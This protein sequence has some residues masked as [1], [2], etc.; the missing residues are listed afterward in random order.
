MTETEKAQFERIKDAYL[1]MLNQACG[2]WDGP[3][4]KGYD[5]MYLSSY[6]RAID[7]AFELGWIKEEEM[8]R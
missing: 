3:T 8:L 1:E 4:F 5:S 2:D 7:L 6:E